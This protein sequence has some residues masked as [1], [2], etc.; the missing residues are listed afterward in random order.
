MVPIDGGRQVQ[1]RL[2]QA[3]DMRRL[4]QVLAPDHLSHALVGV[5]DHHR[6]MI[7][8]P[9]VL[10]R[11]D[12]VARQ[13]GAGEDTAR[14]AAGPAPHL[15]EGQAVEAAEGALR[16]RQRKA[17]GEGPPLGEEGGLLAR[18]RGAGPEGFGLAMGRAADLVQRGL[19]GAETAIE[20]APVGQA[21]QGRGVGLP[22]QRLA[23]DGGLPVKAEPGQILQDPGLVF[24]P[25]PGR[26]DILDPQEEPALRRPR[27][28]VGR[29]GRIGVAAMQ[30]SRRRGR[31][32]GDERRDGPIPLKAA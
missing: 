21:G 3:L 25:R 6:Q 19:A 24:A 27:R 22:S 28:P 29:Q 31:E 32:A 20:Q 11:Q 26:V 9:Q 12:H 10:A 2:K 14:L 4:E 16:G 18:R 17:Q 30:A 13:I 5:V 7:A 23:P 8:D 1:Q 15:L